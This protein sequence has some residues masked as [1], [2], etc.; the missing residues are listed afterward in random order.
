[1]HNFTHFS[2]H[3]FIK[4]SC[5]QCCA[6]C[7]SHSSLAWIDWYFLLVKN[8]FSN[9]VRGDEFI[10]VGYS[11]SSLQSADVFFLSCR[12]THEPRHTSALDT[13][14][15]KRQS[16]QDSLSHFVN[17]V[18]TKFLL[19][20]S[21]ASRITDLVLFGLW[22]NPTIMHKHEIITLDQIRFFAILKHW[23]VKWESK[24][25]FLQSSNCNTRVSQNLIIAKVV[26]KCAS[27]I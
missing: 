3:F 7:A 27:L 16:P 5:P 1:M 13:Q 18:W 20:L 2:K 11:C 23:N 24:W 9:F 26:R 21:W 17:L 8:W 14:N 25:W 10:L 4:F 22:I 12:V 19:V 6:K 15:Q